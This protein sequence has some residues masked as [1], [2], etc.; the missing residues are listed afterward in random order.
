MEVHFWPKKDV[1][2][3]EPSVTYVYS[4]A[5]QPELC[6]WKCPTHWTLTLLLMHLP[7]WHQG[8][9]HR[10]TLPDNGTNFVGAEC[11]LWELVEAHDT[12]RIMQET[13]KY[14]PI[15]W[16]FNPPSAP[17]LGGVFEPLIK[18][19]KKAIKAV[20][21]D[22]DGTDKKLHLAICAVE[23]LLNSWPIT[24]VSSDP[25]DLSPLTPSCFREIG[26]LFPPEDIDHDQAYN[27]RKRLHR[28]Q[29]LLGQFWK[30]W[31]QEFLP[32]LNVRKKWFH[33]RHSLMEGDDVLMKCQQRRVAS[34]SCIFYFFILFIL[35]LINYKRK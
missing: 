5:S 16:K 26:G 32:S 30:R 8:G 33:A 23:R 21:G 35:P 1:V 6:I 4:L 13:S 9:G 15:D 3:Q 10:P 25:D 2:G 24:Y 12:D 22:R 18:S 20:L 14:H 7:G 28:V 31:R 29:Q 11:E 34:R 19:V 27:P 17:H